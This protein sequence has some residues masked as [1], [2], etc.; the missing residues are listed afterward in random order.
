LAV[1][2]RLSARR[3]ASRISPTVAC[4]VIDHGPHKP[5]RD[6]KG[7]QFSL[8][9]VSEWEAV[10]GFDRPA[11]ACACD[12]SGRHVLGVRLDAESAAHLT[13][14]NP[15]HTKGTSMK[16]VVATTVLAIAASSLVYGHAQSQPIPDRRS[17]HDAP[18]VEALEQLEAE[19]HAAS[20]KGDT[21][22]LER[23]W[24]DEYTLTTPNGRVIGKAELL[25]MLRSGALKYEVLE[26]E[27]LEISVYGD[28]AVVTGRVAVRAKV[29]GSF[30]NGHDRYLTVY[31]KRQGE[32]KQ[33]ATQAARIAQR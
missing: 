2:T 28:A 15:V 10:L 16:L 20:L 7:G 22:A 17:P 23:V 4:F 21:A 19:F 25:A 24:A 13:G 18:A 5:S 32:W 14:L 31:V 29:P 26:P 3:T 11:A 6:G 33:V 27:G 1:G 12:K 30:T 8:Y 9:C